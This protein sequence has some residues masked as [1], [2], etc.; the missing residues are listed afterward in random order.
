MKKILAIGWKDLLIIYRDRAAWIMMLAA[1]L[2]LTVA[3]GFVTGSFGDDDNSGPQQIGA[4][5]VNQ[6][7]GQVAAGLVE[8]L[9]AEELA[10]L[11]AP[12]TAPSATAARQTVD[13]DRAAAAVIIPADFSA[14]L[15]DGSDMAGAVEIYTNPGRPISASIV[16]S[17]VA[18][19]LSQVE[20]AL[21]S[22][23]V[24]A[25][26]LLSSGR[27]TPEEVATV[28]GAAATQWEAGQSAAITIDRETATVQEES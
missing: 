14:T 23:Q 9:Q 20:M 26:Q 21:V 17:I 16:E 5:I 4:V 10:G 25:S 11:L 15:T 8:T 18:D 3:M 6:D 24:T 7:V 27:V 28:A 1:P 2:V 22:S 12:T 13:D 19:Y